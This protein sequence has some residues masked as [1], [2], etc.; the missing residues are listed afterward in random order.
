MLSVSLV[1]SSLYFFAG[2][3]LILVESGPNEVRFSGVE[4]GHQREE[5]FLVE[6]GHLQVQVQEGRHL[7]SFLFNFTSLAM[8]VQWDFW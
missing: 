8:T 6:G 4:G 7:H 3:S 1:L 2:I 5:L